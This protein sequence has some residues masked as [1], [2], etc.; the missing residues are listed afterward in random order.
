MTKISFSWR[1]SE[2]WHP[3]HPGSS[4]KPEPCRHPLGIIDALTQV[5]KIFLHGRFHAREENRVLSLD[6]MTYQ[7]RLSDTS[8]PVDN[9]AFIPLPLIPALHGR[10]FLFASDKHVLPPL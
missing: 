4:Q 9:E 5:L 7:S 1:A 8:P 10:Q 3:A 6:E 2:V